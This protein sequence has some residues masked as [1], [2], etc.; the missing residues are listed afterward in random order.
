MRSSCR[1]AIPRPFVRPIKEA[2][3][4]LVCQVHDVEAAHEAQ[5]IGADI[6][7]AQGAEA[8]GTARCVPRCRSFRR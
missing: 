8:G 3:C 1:S 4:L 7:I 6:V 5:A 2:G